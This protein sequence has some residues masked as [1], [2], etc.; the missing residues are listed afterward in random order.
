MRLEIVFATP[1][2]ILLPWSY[3]DWLRA[4]VYHLLRIHNQLVAEWLHQEGT[5]LD[6]KRYKPFNFS[7]LY[8]SQ[9]R[10]HKKGLIVKGELKW[11]FSSPAQ[12]ICYLIAEELLHTP[13]RLGPH[14]LEVLKVSSLQPPAFSSPSLF[15]TLSP[16]SSST[17][18]VEGGKM[19][20][21]Y[22]SPDEESFKLSLKNNL[23]HKASA[24]WLPQG[25]VDIELLPPFRSR[26]FK[27]KGIDVRGW[28]MRLK[29]SGD[30]HLLKLAYD[31]GLGEHNA[32]GFGMLS[33]QRNSQ[34][35][36]EK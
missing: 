30:E 2:E 21:V 12:I 14:I 34:G 19:R 17:G 27:I 23:L 11:Y 29:L 7:L 1:G 13:I 31:V 15:T 20:K 5:P 6:D 22:L 33:F 28:D 3:L 24:L 35:G 26:L 4:L 8:P 9:K 25:D 32:C 16:I 10:T 36:E 18:V